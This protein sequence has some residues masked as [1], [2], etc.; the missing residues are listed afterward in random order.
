MT[1]GDAFPVGAHDPVARHKAIAGIRR[2][3]RISS[4]H[5]DMQMIVMPGIGNNAGY[6][7]II[8]QHPQDV[9]MSHERLS[10]EHCIVVIV[11]GAGNIQWRW[12]S[13]F[14]NWAYV[15]TFSILMRMMGRKIAHVGVRHVTNSDKGARI[16][17]MILRYPYDRLNAGLRTVLLIHWAI[18]IISVP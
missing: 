12:H 6:P 11:V 1:G 7:V 17:K 3:L 9:P 16:A 15:D 18:R 13:V 8:E 4:P 10:Q 5:N 2:I 14:S